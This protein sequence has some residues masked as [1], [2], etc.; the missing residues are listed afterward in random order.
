VGSLEDLASL[1]RRIAVTVPGTVAPDVLR[2]VFS[3]P[4]ASGRLVF[5][6]STFKRAI[7]EVMMG[8]PESVRVAMVH[9]LF[10]PR[11]RRAEA[12]YAVVCPV[13]G[14][15]EDAAEAVAFLARLGLNVQ[16]MDWRSHDR[17]VAFTIG[18]TYAV[19]EALGL[20]LEEEGLTLDSLLPATTFRYLRVM[21]E[22]IL[23]DP[24]SLRGEILG[25]PEVARVARLLAKALEE[26]ASGGRS[27][28][29][30][31]PAGYEKLY[32]CLEECRV[33]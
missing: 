23:S 11:A 10:G 8:A 26:V 1:S 24:E 9:P 7:V 25:E 16:V 32:H 3:L 18:L 2:T 19:A 5:E 29:K 6:V 33:D 14:R 20:A 30:G 13:P 17:L 27:R 4:E 22:A 21:V 31:S 15:E 12:H 28:L